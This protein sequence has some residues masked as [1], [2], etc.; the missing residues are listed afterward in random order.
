MTA[1][2]LIVTTLADALTAISILTTE[3]DKLLRS[4]IRLR[5]D[6]E[7]IGLMCADYDGEDLR[8]ECKQALDDD[9]RALPWQSR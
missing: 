3:R 9:E 4:R 1:D 2:R 7:R 6:I 8:R 5:G